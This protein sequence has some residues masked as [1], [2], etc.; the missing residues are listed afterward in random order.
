MRARA[1]VPAWH[2]PAAARARE[3]THGLTREGPTWE[4]SQ[5]RQGTEAGVAGARAAPAQ[6][7]E[8][9]RAYRH[10]PADQ[11]LEAGG[12]SWQGWV[13]EIHDGRRHRSRRTAPT[14]ACWGCRASELNT[15]LLRPRQ[16][17]RG[18]GCARSM[19]PEVAKKFFPQARGPQPRRR[20]P[21]C[22]ADA[23]AGCVHLSSAAEPAHAHCLHQP[24]LVESFV[25]RAPRGNSAPAGLRCGRTR[26]C[27]LGR[28]AHT[29]IQHCC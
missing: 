1:P 5:G 24:V 21:P 2:L 10:P 22:D 13:L 19:V 9:T 15:S 6:D 25:L 26:A 18:S 12:N 8:N 11:R 27:T 23:C 7:L 20:Q 14:S 17:V 3:C 29:G 4:G 16:A 28:P